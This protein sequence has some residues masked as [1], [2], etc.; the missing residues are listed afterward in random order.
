MQKKKINF[1]SIINLEY[2]KLIQ[3]KQAPNEHQINVF[4]PIYR[5]ILLFWRTQ[6][7]SRGKSIYITKTEQGAGIMQQKELIF[8]FHNPNSEKDTYNALMNMFVD[9]GCKKL[10]KALLEADKEQ[11]KKENVK[12]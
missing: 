11:L 7:Y 3:Y 10:R 9:V 2:R 6:N 8:R 4:M 1:L 12:E 5:Y